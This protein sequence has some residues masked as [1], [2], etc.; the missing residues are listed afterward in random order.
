MK[1]L[2]THARLVSP[3]WTV[4]D[5]TLAVENGRITAPF[6]EAE[7]DEVIDLGG[8]LLLPG[9]FDVHF[10]GCAG[11]DFSDGTAEAVR[12]IAR[13]KL[14]QGVT[15]F[16]GTTLTL[17]ENELVA[18]LEAGRDYMRT[19]DGAELAGIHLE[20]PFFAPKSA[21]AQNPAHLRKPDIELVDRLN[22]IFPVRKVS[23]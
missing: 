18:A 8:A 2:F 9:F 12:T 19:P 17:P 23:Y 5:G 13:K 7:T 20:G 21:G 22:A 16:L 10:H 6:P 1:Q 4:E 14:K 3:G 11:S 15:T